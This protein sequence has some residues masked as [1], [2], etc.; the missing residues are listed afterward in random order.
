MAGHIKVLPI[1]PQDTGDLARDV[2]RRL[3]LVRR[4]T[5]LSQVE[6]GKRAGLSQAQYHQYESGKRRLTIEA[7]LSLCHVYLLTLDYLYRGDPSGL[8]YQLALKIR[9]LSR[10]D[11]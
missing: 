3:G 6:F 11:S 1:D 9:D 8:P 7:A 5:G 4:A 10:T 2:G